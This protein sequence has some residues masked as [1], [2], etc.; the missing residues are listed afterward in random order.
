MR[1]VSSTWF[2]FLWK[3]LCQLLEVAGPDRPVPE[4]KV[5]PMKENAPG[6]AK[7]GTGM[8]KNARELKTAASS[9][10]SDL[11]GRLHSALT[12]RGCVPGPFLH[13]RKSDS[14]FMSSEDLAALN[15]RL[16]SLEEGSRT[17]VAQV[18]SV[19]KFWYYHAFLLF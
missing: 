12:E 1:C 2:K 18:G 5:P 11:Y 4:P 10:T 19:E 15:N 9:T 3:L 13:N 8:G 14:S 7:D 17:M 16:E 6:V